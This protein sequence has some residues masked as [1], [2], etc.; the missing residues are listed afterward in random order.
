MYF[1][2][3]VWQKV[4][5]RE[6]TVLCSLWAQDFF[7]SFG[8]DPLGVVTYAVTYNPELRNIHFMS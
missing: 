2:V 6:E 5:Y 3:K 1:Y 7:L 8:S 4:V